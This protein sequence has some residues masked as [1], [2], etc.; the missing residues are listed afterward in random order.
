MPA[1][2]RASRKRAKYFCNCAESASASKL[3]RSSRIKKE[4]RPAA[5]FFFRLLAAVLFL[6]LGVNRAHHHTSA[7]R[8]VRRK[9]PSQRGKPF[10]RRSQLPRAR[11]P[12]RC[13]AL[14]VLAKFFF[15]R[16]FVPIG[17]LRRRHAGLRIRQ[18]PIRNSIRAPHIADPGTRA[19][20]EFESAIR[21]QMQKA[22]KVAP[23]ICRS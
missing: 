8:I 17:N 16:R 11:E 3:G 21:N 23:R 4:Q 9:L 22:A 1:A 6:L 18:Q 2:K 5:A 20:D 12:C 10:P 7:A 15:E 19:N 14:G 13:G